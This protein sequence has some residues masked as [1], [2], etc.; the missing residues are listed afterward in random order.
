MLVLAD[1]HACVLAPKRHCVTTNYPS[2]GYSLPPASRN[3]NLLCDE[4]SILFPLTGSIFRPVSFHFV[5]L[6]RSIVFHSLPLHSTLSISVPF[7]S[8]PFCVVPF[9]FMSFHSVL[10]RFFVPVPSRA[11]EFEKRDGSL[12]AI[13]MC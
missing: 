2:H 9:R 4:T 8:I 12:E 11:I 10:L 6:Y 1:I 13:M 5:S 7:R 3:L